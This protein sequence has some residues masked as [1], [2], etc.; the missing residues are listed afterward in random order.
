MRTGQVLS[1]RGWALENVVARISREAG[2]RVTTNV[3]MRAVV[4]S[5]PLTPHWYAL[6]RDGTPVGRAAQQDGVVL[7]S[8]R[9][10][11]ERTY[12]ELLGRRA[13]SKL[14]VL[15]VEVGG[16][17]S[18]ETTMFLSLL[19]RAKVRCENPVL[20]KRIQQA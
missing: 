6:H 14:V 7:Q 9:R 5:W 16:R 3:F 10:R 1:K 4:L 13:R 8:A 15:A 20:R 2:G 18:E 12:P 19:A 17:W 11:K